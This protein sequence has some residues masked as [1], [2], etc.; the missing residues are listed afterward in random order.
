VGDAT[1]ENV[2]IGS[3]TAVSGG[4]E[5]TLVSSPAGQLI[6]KAGWNYFLIEGDG[7]EGVQNPSFALDVIKASIDAL[8]SAAS[9]E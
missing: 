1:Y 6:A 9:E 5:L 3:D 4:S 7:S 8:E 2:R